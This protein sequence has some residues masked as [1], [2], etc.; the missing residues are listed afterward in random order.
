MK[1]NSCNGFEYYYSNQ[2]LAWE[3][4]LKDELVAEE[5]GEGRREGLRLD[6]EAQE[7]DGEADRAL[8]RTEPGMGDEFQKLRKICNLKTV[9]QCT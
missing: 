6:V 8:P 1:M 5:E 7:A 4:L 3:S 2:L 9:I